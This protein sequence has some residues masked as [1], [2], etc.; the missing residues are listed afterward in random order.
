[1]AGS[2]YRR[3]S[4]GADGPAR[5][6]HALD[7][8]ADLDLI[9]RAQLGIPGAA[10]EALIRAGEYGHA[11]FDLRDLAGQEVRLADKLGGEARPRTLVDVLGR[12]DLLNEAVAHDGDAVGK[13]ERLL[14]I[15]GDVEESDA[16]ALLDVL[17]LALH[18]LAQLQ[19]ERAQRLVQQKEPRL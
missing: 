13:V 2:E 9:A 18:L 12:A 8:Q 15:V 17:Q 5:E 4:A 16:G 11:I 19:V 1:M 3:Q 10:G 7:A 14:L 6:A